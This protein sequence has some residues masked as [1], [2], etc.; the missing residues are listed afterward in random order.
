MR[1]KGIPMRS[2]MIALCLITTPV[3]A[4]DYIQP[5]NAPLVLASPN[6]AVAVGTPV[7]GMLYQPIPPVGHA[8]PI[9]PNAEPIWVQPSVS[10][11]PQAR[12]PIIAPQGRTDRCVGAA[13]R[14]SGV[15]AGRQEH[16]VGPVLDTAGIPFVFREHGTQ[17][18]WAPEG[19]MVVSLDASGRVSG[20]HCAGWVNARR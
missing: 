6:G 19:I 18:A 11:V 1:T 2:F 9:A 7:P 20:L 15:L 10:V 4:G 17:N 3:M 12:H 13:W 8:H 5:V 14:H 16:Q